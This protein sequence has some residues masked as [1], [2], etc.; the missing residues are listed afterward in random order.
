LRLQTVKKVFSGP[1]NERDQA[2]S[3]PATQAH[4]RCVEETGTDTTTY[5]EVYRHAEATSCGLVLS[6]LLG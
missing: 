1:R 5:R 4:K 3:K 2:R 6:G